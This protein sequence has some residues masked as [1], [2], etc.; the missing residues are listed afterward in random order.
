MESDA[1]W[2]LL[3]ALHPSAAAKPQASALR[4]A[5]KSLLL[6]VEQQADEIARLEAELDVTTRDLD[7]LL[8][9]RRRSRDGTRGGEHDEGAS[10]PTTARGTG[11]P[12][13]GGA[14]C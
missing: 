11:P 1:R 12:N 4:A 2:K 9:E 7:R 3:A 14:P 13:D 5:A 10:G 6:L 8:E